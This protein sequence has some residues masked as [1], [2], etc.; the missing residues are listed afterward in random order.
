MNNR[1]DG[2]DI[3][4]DLL[5]KNWRLRGG[6]QQ[7]RN[8]G[9]G[10]GLAQALDPVGLGNSTRVNSDL[11]Y[12]LR[13]IGKEQDWDIDFQLSFFNSSVESE[14][15]FRLF[16]AGA[17][18]GFGAPFPDGVI[19]TP[20]I[21]EEHYRFNLV[22]KY[23]GFNRHQM[24]FGSGYAYRDLYRIKERKNFSI[25][26]NGQLIPPGSPIVD[27]SDTPYVFNQE[28][29]RTSRYL[30]IQDRWD[31]AN[32]WQATSGLRYDHY[33]DFGGVFNPRFALVWSTSLNLTSKFL[34]GKA[35]RAPSFAETRNINNPVAL[36]NLNLKPE[37]IETLEFALDYR[38]HKDLHLGGN[39]FWS[40]WTNI[41]K[42]V[43]DVGGAS[44]TA[45]NVGQQETYGVELEV[46]WQIIKNL[47]LKGNYAS[48]KS[49]DQI[50]E[51]RAPLVPNSQV[52]LRL[53][54]KVKQNLSL[55]LTANRV[56][57]RVRNILDFRPTIKDYTLVDFNAN[58]QL[59]LNNVELSLRIKNLL[60]QD[61]REP[62]PFGQ[63]IDNDL[64]LAGRQ[65]Y[66]QIG[67]KY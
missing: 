11:S 66:F 34:Y 21:F 30:F 39:I 48:Q 13:S 19:G 27:V 38:V 58:W 17:D 28:G 46:D 47:S 41:I 3:R 29:D 52:Y 56:M 2:Y 20:E 8:L 63:F 25:G 1:R 35:F 59:D 23:K 54:W 16:P 49:H 5:Y 37:T 12:Q 14:N 44:N 53:D 64:P 57:G 65:V 42:F 22:A 43:P 45:Q 62:T 9:L 31:I 6:I 40:D 4:V 33:S 36:G 26:P 32:D 15:D 61:A 24:D 7:R 51:F 18:I 67:Y 60:D 10:V 50:T 55:H